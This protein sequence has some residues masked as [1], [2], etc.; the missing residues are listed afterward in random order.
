MDR[1][2][3][4]IVD[5]HHDVRRM[6]HAWVKTLGP[7]YEV[8]AMPSG[9]E[10][11]LDA[12]RQP[13][14]LLIAD[15]RLPGI[16]GLELMAKIKRRYPDLKVILIT[17]MS[18]PKIR[19]QVAE[20][21][22]DA[23]FIK[24][25]EMPDFLDA[26]ERLLGTVE[27]FLPPAPIFEESPQPFKG[28]SEYLADLRQTT[29]AVAAYLL[30]DGGEVQA[31]AGHMAEENTESNLILAINAAHHAGLKVSYAL[32]IKIP[33]NLMFFK[34]R[35]YHLCIA[36]VGAAHTI[37]LVFDAMHQADFPLAV[38]GPVFQ[39]AEEILESL[40]RVSAAAPATPQELPETPPEAGFPVEPVETILLPQEED[41]QPE[42]VDIPDLN[43]LFKKEKTALDTKQVDSFWDAAVE[44]DGTNGAGS[45]SALSYDEARRLGLA[46]NDEP[47]S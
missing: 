3:V 13:V 18:D 8:L 1:Y 27:T 37:L 10:A 36:P 7:Q 47:A 2:R 28:P 32:G 33:N 40:S 34:G 15:F 39:A 6:L 5:D 45:A 43:E 11:I 16:T 12:S 9:E 14:D 41:L 22:A 4:I 42:P 19:R 20:A 35:Q 21:G 23:F 30:D 24:P 29:Q 17:G 46:P 26:V 25:V 31:S 38:N 44:Q